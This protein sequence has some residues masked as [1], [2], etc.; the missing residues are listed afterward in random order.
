M[1]FSCLLYQSVSKKPISRSETSS[2]D[3]AFPP[4]LKETLNRLYHLRRG[5]L[6][7]PGP[8][9]AMD[10]RAEQRR[11]FLR[12]PVKD[13]LI[14]MRPELWS[15]GSM[16]ISSG[17][18]TMLEFP[19]E[20]LALWDDVSFC[21]SSIDTRL[22]IAISHDIPIISVSCRVSSLPIST[23][24]CSFGLGPIALRKDTMASVTSS[25][26]TC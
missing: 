26:L 17:W 1:S 20:T 7:S 19:P 4:Q 3:I 15:T 23:T 6:I 18:D 10:D 21:H 11:L 5:P 13:C 2:L 12:F 14:M 9:R 16:T 24:P 8:M 25:R 22:L